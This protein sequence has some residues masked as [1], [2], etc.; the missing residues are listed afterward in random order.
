MITEAM[1]TKLIDNGFKR[2][3]KGNYDRLYINA[4]NLGLVCEYYNTGNVKH[5]E[6]NGVGISNCEARRMKAANTFIDIKTG[7]IYSDNETLKLSVID[8]VN[9]L[10][11]KED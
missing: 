3:T 8:M 2:W 11:D 7:R 10:A 1:I 4:S 9:T 5:A 6:Y